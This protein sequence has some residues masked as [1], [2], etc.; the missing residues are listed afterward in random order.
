MFPRLSILVL[1][2][3]L[4]SGIARQALAQ[5]ATV[6]D[7]IEQRV[8][9]CAICH[10]KQGEG[11]RKNEY[12]P[13]LAGKPAG[14]L[15]NQLL[16]YRER[17]REFAIMNYLVAWLSDAYLAEIADY[18]AKL[19]PPYPDPAFRAPLDVLTQGKK[20]VTEGD[21]SRNLP[22]CTA[23]H[24]EALAGMQPAIPG[25]IGLYPDY[26]AAQMGAWAAGQRHAMAPDCMAKVAEKLTREDVAAIT[27][28]LVAQPAKGDAKPLP[29]GSLKLPLECGGLTKK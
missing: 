1:A 20:L 3:L 12:F 10:G 8:T 14:Y 6:P 9:A 21:P 15:Y 2:P 5:A 23:C 16:N 13:R 24:G 17:R 29:P 27:A 11:L 18:Y 19:S 7:T 25:L 22:A 4:A 28:Y 26:I